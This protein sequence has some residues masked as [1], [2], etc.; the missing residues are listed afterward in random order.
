MNTSHA[1]LPFSRKLCA[2]TAVFAIATVATVAPAMAG[3][4]Q[5]WGDTGWTYYDKRECCEEAVW[6]AQD[7]SAR[8][9][10]DTGG[11]PKIR[12][13][14]SRGLCDW[15]ARGGTHDRIYRCT[16]KTTVDCR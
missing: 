9:C 7:E 2:I 16:A 15:D 3:G 8:A 4:Y 11:N 1:P 10:L 12:S 13:G 14:T 5:G 6:M